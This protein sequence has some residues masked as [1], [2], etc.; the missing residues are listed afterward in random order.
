M[1]LKQKL[2]HGPVKFVP[3]LEVSAHNDRVMEADYQI[4]L[5]LA[6]LKESRHPNWVSLKSRPT[7]LGDRKNRPG[8][9]V[10]HA[11][12]LIENTWH[13]ALIEN[14]SR[15]FATQVDKALTEGSD[16]TLGLS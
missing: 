7:C 16:E 3:D 12:A 2:S 14:A 4:V 13:D 10:E 1:S 9:S 11:E 5:R 6:A 8:R 15:I